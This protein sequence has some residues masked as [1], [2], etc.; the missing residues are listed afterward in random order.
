MIITSTRVAEDSVHDLRLFEGVE[1]EDER[2]AVAIA[3]QLTLVHR[4][5]VEAE[6][7][8]QSAKHVRDSVIGSD[9]GIVESRLPVP[10]VRVVHVSLGTPGNARGVRVVGHVR[11]EDPALDALPAAVVM[12]EARAVLVNV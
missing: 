11:K 1:L 12:P 8:A 9:V 10:V 7:F 5:R 6:A 3:S 2:V 4:V